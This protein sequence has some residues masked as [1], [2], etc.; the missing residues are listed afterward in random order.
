LLFFL[1]FLD[2]IYF[3]LCPPRHRHPP[4]AFKTASAFNADLSKWNTAAVTNMQYSTS[5]SPPFSVVLAN[6][7]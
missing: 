4:T 1:R 3:G 5:T 6:F 7:T 2:F